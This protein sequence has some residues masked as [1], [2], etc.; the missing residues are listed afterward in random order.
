[1]TEPG[2]DWDIV[3]VG[4]GAAAIAA[5]Q[6]LQEAGARFLLVE[7]RDRLGGRALTRPTE[8]G[9]AIDLGCEWLHSAERNPWTGIARRLGFAIDQTLPDWG[10]R[11]AR[12]GGEDAQRAWF[13]AAAAYYE[14]LER[15]AETGPDRPASDFLAPGGPWN[16][17]LGAISTWANGTEPERLSILD[18]AN[19]ANDGVNWRVLRGYGALIAAHGAG[20]PVRLAT[21]VRRLDHRGRRIAIETDRGTLSARAVIVTVSTDLL[22]AGAIEF[23]PDLPDKRDAARGL[24]LGVANKLFLALD[25]TLDDSGEEFPRD[26]HEVGR[27]DRVATGSYQLRPHGWPMISAY[28]GGRLA[29]E[30]EAAGADAMAAFATDELA[31]LLGSG[32]RR[33]LRPLA[34]SAWAADPWARGSYS[35]ALPGRAGDRQSLAAPVDDRLFFAG[36]ACSVADF[37]TAH[38]AYASGRAAAE[39]AL[40]GRTA[41]PSV[42]S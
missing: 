37:G 16:G 24:P 4:A 19:Y 29:Q 17:L 5:G 11:V 39:M 30:L 2:S 12:H 20:L 25:G 15:A 40:S 23:L 22:A 38:G 26:R 18:Y 1:V 21:A 6:R 10:Q 27:T 28:F 9:H 32:V 33:R 41:Q 3:I 8:R 34:A 35:I 31:G 13:A 42:T 36:E 7:A 14:R